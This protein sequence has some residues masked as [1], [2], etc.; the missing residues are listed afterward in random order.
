MLEALISSKTRI[1]LLLRLFLNPDSSAYLRGLA[2]EFNESTNSIR[3][4]LNRFEE[5]GMLDSGLVGNKKVFKANKKYPLFQEVRSILLKYTGLQDV[6]DEVVE[7]LGDLNKVYLSG[8]LALG[9]DSDVVSL[10]FI[11]NP[12][13]HYLVQLIQKAESLVPKKI[14]YLVYSNE[15]AAIMTFD[16][17]Q[18]LLIWNE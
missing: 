3:V 6:I 10:I 7:K 13:L 12:D 8:D 17:N 4:E 18:N 11:G 1:K 5:A 16:P 9:K 15:E 2:E 14:Q